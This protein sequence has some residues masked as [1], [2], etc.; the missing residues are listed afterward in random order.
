MVRY[1]G[2]V[3]TGTPYEGLNTA[4]GTSGTATMP[5]VTTSGN[6]RMVVLLCTSAD[7]N[8][9]SDFAGGTNTSPNVLAQDAF[10]ATTQG[11]D[12]SLEHQSGDQRLPATIS[13]N[14]STVTGG[15]G[16]NDD[17]VITGFALI[18]G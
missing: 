6:N 8:T 3:T 11:N 17:Y 15:G 5:S 16:G 1:R 7:D 18:P 10:F 9:W 13:G 12:S 4:S 14:T 2:V